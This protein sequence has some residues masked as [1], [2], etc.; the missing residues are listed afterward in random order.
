MWTEI[1]RRK[2]EREGQRGTVNLACPAGLC[3]LTEMGNR[4]E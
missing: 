1:T 3:W 4:V 2:Y